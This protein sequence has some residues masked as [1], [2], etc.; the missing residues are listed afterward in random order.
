MAH[1]LV[2]DDDPLAFQVV[3]DALHSLD[4]YVYQADGWGAMNLELGKRPHA[5]VL[6][7]VNMPGVTGDKLVPAIVRGGAHDAFPPPM[8]LLHSSMDIPKL[9]RLAREVGASGIVPKGCSESELRNRVG[10]AI[11]TWEKLVSGK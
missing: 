5:L 1:V 8:V 10:A 6:L 2:V 4:H 3:N 9:R 7:D 11:E